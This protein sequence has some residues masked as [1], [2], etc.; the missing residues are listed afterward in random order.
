MSVAPIAAPPAVADAGAP[1]A[2]KKVSQCP[3]LAPNEVSDDDH[4]P[5]AGA[6]ALIQTDHWLEERGVSAAA[7]RPY[8]GMCHTAKLGAA[9]EDA[10]ICDATAG[11]PGQ[12]ILRQRL[13]G[14][15]VRDRKPVVVFDVPIGLRHLEWVMERPLD[16]ALVL[17]P[18]GTQ[19]DLVDRAPEGT[20][21]VAPPSQCA[22][23]ERLVE[24]CVKL[25]DEKNPIPPTCYWNQSMQPRDFK[26]RVVP[27]KSIEFPAALHDCEHAKKEHHFEPDSRPIAAQMCGQRGH[28][29]WKNDRFVRER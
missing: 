12:M 14:V 15:V 3:P 13:Q 9:R 8:S 28:Y 1:A 5:L 17:D 18:S 19:F 23:E 27:M 26:D 21:L 24:Q 16:L 22:T 4:P 25:R 29:V 11:P 6:G 7:A 10:I 20:Q 2:P